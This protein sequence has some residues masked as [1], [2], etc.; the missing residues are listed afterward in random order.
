[1]TP[2]IGITTYRERARWGVWDADA[3]LLPS[4]YADAIRLAGGVPVL[5][6]PVDRPHEIAAD[7]VAPLDG[8]LIA[9][10]ADVDPG[11]YGAEPGAA[12]TGWRSDRD[13]WEFALLRAAERRDIAVLG[14]CRGMQVM[15]THAGGT[16]IQHLPD[17]VGHDRHSPGADIYGTIDADVTTGSRLFALVGGQVRVGCH[18]H[19]A[20]ASHPGFEPVAHAT[21]GTLEAI[22]R[23]DRPFWLGVQW[24]PEVSADNGLFTG[25]MRAAEDIRSHQHSQ[26]S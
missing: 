10:G 1:M 5:L 20:V 4:A 2:M 15:A 18:H 13:A 12:T 7:A 25:F 14:T 9:G 23:T 3:D 22:D 11:R 17:V 19:Q 16:L 8:L 6:P 21:D 26:S 24:H